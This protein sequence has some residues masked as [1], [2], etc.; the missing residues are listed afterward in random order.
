MDAFGDVI[1]SYAP[2]TQRL[3]SVVVSVNK[4]GNGYSLALQTNPKRRMPRAVSPVENPFEGKD[5]AELIDNMI[6][7]M[8]ALIRAIND[9][10]AGDGDWKGEDDREKVREAFKVMFPGMARNIQ[11]LTEASDEEPQEEPRF[12]SLVFETKKSLMEYLEKNL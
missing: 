7:G 5:P 1:S 4:V 3:P 12:E 11:Q 2:G 10:G 8:G 6:D 9:K